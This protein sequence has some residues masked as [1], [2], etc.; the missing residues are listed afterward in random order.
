MTANENEWNTARHFLGDQAD[1]LAYKIHDL[2]KKDEYSCSAV[3]NKEVRIEKIDGS[4]DGY[5][6]IRVSGQETVYGVLLKCSDMGSFTGGGSHRTTLRLLKMA[7]DEKWRLK[8]IFIVGCCGARF[9]AAE[10]GNTQQSETSGRP[11]EENG[12]EG[13]VFIA[14]DIVQYAI[15]KFERERE[16]KYNVRIHNVSKD[17]DGIMDAEKD[18]KKCIDPVYKVL[19]YSG[20]FVIKTDDVA[21]DL[22]GQI[23]NQLKV[24]FEMEGI[25]VTK[26]IDDWTLL[27]GDELQ[28]EIVLV[29]GVSDQ[30]GADKKYPK[31]T[32]FFSKLMKEVPEDARQQMCTVMSLSLVL[33]AIIARRNYF[34]GPSDKLVT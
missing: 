24:G 5:K 18:S 29:K 9:A 23:S 4:F 19:F 13:A 8:V 34:S 6:L 3:L 15:G 7:Q 22:S 2:L 31:D 28:P 32:M 26:A 16:I 1:D 17:W 20:D 25:G 14:K 11:D 30:A 10:V 27:N 12:R 33:R 21:E